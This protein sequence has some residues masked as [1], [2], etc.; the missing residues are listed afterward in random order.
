[1]LAHSSPISMDITREG[2]PSMHLASLDTMHAHP[3]YL[4]MV[5]M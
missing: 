3:F 2:P 4:I 1:V 5:W